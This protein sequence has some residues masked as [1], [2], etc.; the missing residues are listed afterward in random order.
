MKERQMSENEKN[1]SSILMQ[2]LILGIFALVFGVFLLIGNRQA[3]TLVGLAVSIYLLID[4]AWETIRGFVLRDRIGTSVGLIRGI[5]G[6]IVAG[7]VL[8]L[9]LGL[10]ALSLNTGFTILGIGLIAYGGLGLFTDF[11]ERGSRR[12]NWGSVAI[13]VLLLAWG[14]LIFFAR[15]QDFDLQTWSAIILI[16]LGLVGL[17]YYWFTRED[18][19]EA[20]EVD[21]E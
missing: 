21:L 10:D 3:G 2:P 7:L 20:P 17:A 12:M 15:A 5:I 16:A 18:E 1:S 11:F 8:F 9:H 4:G 19:S 13:N 14:I 6:L